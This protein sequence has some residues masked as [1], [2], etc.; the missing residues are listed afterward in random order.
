MI[1]LTQD[2][3]TTTSDSTNKFDNI[4]KYIYYHMNTLLKHHTLQIL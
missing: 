2:I 1:D 3:T 4:I